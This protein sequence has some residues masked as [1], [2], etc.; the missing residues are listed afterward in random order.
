MFLAMTF[1]IE[2]LSSQVLLT[3]SFVTLALYKQT[4]GCDSAA[5]G[6][7]ESAIQDTERGTRCLL[8]Q[9]GPQISVGD[10]A[11][12]HQAEIFKNRKL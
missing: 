10:E 9:A 3:R 1:L 6:Q 8:R 5:N 7:A 4:R 12:R 2:A 11:A